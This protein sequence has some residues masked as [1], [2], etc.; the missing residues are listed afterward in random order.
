MVDFEET[1]VRWTPR[2]KR[3]ESISMECAM[4]GGMTGRVGF[5]M[6]SEN[7][8]KRIGDDGECSCGDMSRRDS[9]R[10]YLE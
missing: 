3:V 1:A 6:L 7:R 8:D 10:E 4:K 5:L 2:E 9:I